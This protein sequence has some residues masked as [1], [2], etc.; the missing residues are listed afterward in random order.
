M[1]PSKS[2]VGLF[3]IDESLYSSQLAAVREFKESIS[4]ELRA[5]IAV[6][7]ARELRAHRRARTFAYLLFI[8]PLLAGLAQVALSWFLPALLTGR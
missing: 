4:P 2:D 8:A 1:D 5:R 3:S 6:D 7:D